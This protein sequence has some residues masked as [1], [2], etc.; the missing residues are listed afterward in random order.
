M[1]RGGVSAQ[2]STPSKHLPKLAPQTSSQHLLMENSVCN[3]QGCSAE[4]Q[5]EDMRKRSS[6]EKSNMKLKEERKRN[7]H[8][9][10]SY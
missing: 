1:I 9:D 7:P 6:G 3:N 5:M 8:L 2:V 10:T 4:N